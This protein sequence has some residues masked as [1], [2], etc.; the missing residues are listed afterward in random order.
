MRGERIADEGI[1]LSEDRYE[2]PKEIFKFA[3]GL[4]ESADLP[5]AFSLFDVGCA[6][7]EFAYH[8]KKHNPAITVGGLDVSEAMVAQA[9]K[10]MPGSA[11][12]VGSALESKDFPKRAYDVVTCIGVLTI[13]D[14]P[15]PAIHNL[16]NAAK[17]G[18]LVLF[19]GN[20]TDHDIDVMLRYRRS[21]QGADAPWESGWNLFSHKT[22]DR[23]L[24]E[25]G[26]A[27]TRE[28]HPF[29]LPIDLE[30]TDDPMR[31]WTME[32]ST[33]KHQLVN[34]A[35]QLVNIRFCKV[36]LHP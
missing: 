34:G 31:C 16:L 4:I 22:I 19:T 35:Q 5:E 36:Q 17:P 13:F 6:T 32:T 2:K 28:W 33:N 8:V 21:D 18:G 24:D 11:F 15:A 3:R 9:N 7:G 27:M 25:S 1:Y 30:E 26:H 12:S 20:M 29:E 14:D 10:T 23:I